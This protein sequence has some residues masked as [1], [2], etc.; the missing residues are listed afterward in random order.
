MKQL[1][2]IGFVWLI[3]CAALVSAGSGP[4]EPVI[5]SASDCH[6]NYMASS[7]ARH[8]CNQELFYRVDNATARITAACATKR[9]GQWEKTE[10]TL[11]SSQCGQISNC[12]GTY[13]NTFTR[14]PCRLQH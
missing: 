12:D 11:K 8:S 6:A 4:P 9:P 14:G 13:R 7:S 5:D 3:T 10:I 1:K 2:M